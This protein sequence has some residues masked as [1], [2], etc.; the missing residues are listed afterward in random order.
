MHY[1]SWD[2]TERDAPK[3]IAE[4]GPDVLGV[5]QAD[6][7]SVGG[8]IWDLAVSPE[9]GAVATRGG[10][11]IVRAFDPLRRGDQIR[12]DVEGRG[13]TLVKE[14]SNNWIIDD[15]AGEKVAQFSRASSGVR[16][17]ILEFEGETALPLTDVAALAWLSRS[18]MESRQMASANA[19]IA[20]LVLFSAVA[21][22]VFFL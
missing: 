15:A 11:E 7:A 5:F 9:S 8:E 21:V 19:L 22:L 17:S 16:K 20:T 6:R 12:V 10:E 2:R 4:A 13:Y 3:L 1:V 18:V 14:T